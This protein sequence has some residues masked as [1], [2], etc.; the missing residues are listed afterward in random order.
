MGRVLGDTTTVG[1]LDAAEHV[2]VRGKERASGVPPHPAV[3]VALELISVFE[4][5]DFSGGFCC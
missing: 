5:S 3:S 4:P 2:S 1:A